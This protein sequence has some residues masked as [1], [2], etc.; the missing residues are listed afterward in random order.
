[1]KGAFEQNPVF[2]AEAE[3]D[4]LWNFERCG[5]DCDFRKAQVFTLYLTAGTPCMSNARVPG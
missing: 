1:M 2:L 3:I 5:L 4:K